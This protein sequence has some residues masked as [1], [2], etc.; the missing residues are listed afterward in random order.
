MAADLLNIKLNRLK[1]ILVSYQKVLI[2]YSGGVDSSFLL[3]SASSFLG[4]DKVLA[5]T[6]VSPTYTQKELETAKEI[7]IDLSVGHKI[8][9]TDEVDNPNFK[10]NPQ[11][12]CYYCKSELFLKLQEIAKKEGIGYVLDGTNADDTNDYRPGSQAKKECGVYSPLAEAGLTK[13]DIRTLSKAFGLKTW[14]APAAACLASRFAYGQEITVEDL[15]R[16]EKA[17]AYIRSLGFKMVRVRHYQLSDKTLLA[18]VEVNNSDIPK[19]VGRRSSV[20]N[21]LKELGY[22]YVTLDLEGYRAGSMNEGIK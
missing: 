5:V 13:E 12:R 19:I 14:D 3:K 1:D 2:A 10:A 18:R 16:I 17:E 7:T 4:I 20:V 6:A 15:R 21:C 8:I 22:T 11:N 9:S